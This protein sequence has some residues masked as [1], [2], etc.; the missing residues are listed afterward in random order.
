MKLTKLLSFLLMLLATSSAVAQSQ[1]QFTQFNLNPIFMNPAQT[2]AFEGTYR[3]G[4]IFRS[5]WNVAS[6]YYKP[7]TGY[8]DAPILMVAKRH[9]VG[10]GLMFA[11]DE[12]GQHNLGTRMIALSAAFHYSLDKK[13]KN[14][15]TIGAQ[16]GGANVGLNPTDKS[17][18]FYS[19]LTGNT[20]SDPWT[21]INDRK[22]SYTDFNMGLLFKSTID[23]KSK[24]NIGL[25]VAHITQPNSSLRTNGNINLPIY[26]GLTMGYDRILNNKL[27]IHPTILVHRQTAAFTAN[28][29]A[30]LGYKMPMKGKKEPIVLKGGLGY[31][32]NGHAANILAGAEYKSLVV[33]LAYD[34]NTGALQNAAKNGIE[35]AV[36]YIGKIYKEPKVKGVMVCPKY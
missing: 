13:F 31:D 28:P 36:Q 12:A 18:A 11:R 16:F 7:M 10:L 23:K 17:A 25:M 14:V 5:Q 20:T 30:M 6:P 32:M 2:G 9:W 3:V 1:Y 22:V 4:G 33:G 26:T 35:I 27:S 15:L 34:V 21:S 19:Q 29:Q 24:L 8:V